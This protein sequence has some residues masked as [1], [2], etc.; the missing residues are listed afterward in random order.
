MRTFAYSNET[1]SKILET[2]DEY[3]GAS[4]D[5]KIKVLSS[6]KCD[7]QQVMDA[8]EYLR[9]QEET[10]PTIEISIDLE[11]LSW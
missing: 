9:H 8:L 3:P 11:D 2:L 7:I 10:V 6:I 1:V 5:T 4:F